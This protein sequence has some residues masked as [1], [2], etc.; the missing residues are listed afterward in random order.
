M[1]DLV[2]GRQDPSDQTAILAIKLEG[3]WLILIAYFV[4]SIALIFKFQRFERAIEYIF[5]RDIQA[6]IQIKLSAEMRVSQEDFV[7]VIK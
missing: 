6:P 2:D 4:I 1:N 3:C 7:S 5:N